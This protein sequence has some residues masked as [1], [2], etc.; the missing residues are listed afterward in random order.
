MARYIAKE[1]RFACKECHVWCS[2]REM[3]RSLF[4][5]YPPTCPNCSEVFFINVEW[6]WRVKLEG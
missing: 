3:K 1:E 2:K 4:P 6:M 5:P